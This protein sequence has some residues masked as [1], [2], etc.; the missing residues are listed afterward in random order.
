MC[1]LRFLRLQAGTTHFTENE[2]AQ[3]RARFVSQYRCR[4]PR[5]RQGQPVCEERMLDWC[6]WGA[7]LMC[8]PNDDAA[9]ESHRGHREPAAGAVLALAIQGMTQR[10]R[11]QF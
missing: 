2:N 9:T 3:R 7:W 10:P 1:I 11:V 5:R 4:A 8:R 6:V